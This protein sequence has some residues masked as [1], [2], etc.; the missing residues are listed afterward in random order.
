MSRLT[1]NLVVKIVWHWQK[2]MSTLDVCLDQ[3][4]RRKRPE[5]NPHKYSKLIFGKEERTIQ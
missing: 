4:N 1:I 5:I 2:N 3:W